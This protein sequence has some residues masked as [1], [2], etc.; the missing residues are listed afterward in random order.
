[1]REILFSPLN[2]WREQRPKDPEQLTQNHTAGEWHGTGTS[3][4]LWLPVKYSSSFVPC[5]IQGQGVTVPL[6]CKEAVTWR[7]RCGCSQLCMA[8]E[9][10]YTWWF[11]TVNHYHLQGRAV[12]IGVPAH[13]Y[14][15]GWRHAPRQGQAPVSRLVFLLLLYIFLCWKHIPRWGYFGMLVPFR[16]SLWSVRKHDVRWALPWYPE[17]YTWCLTAFDVRLSDVRCALAF[18]TSSRL[19]FPHPAESHHQPRLTWQPLPVPG[20]GRV[21][22]R[23]EEWLQPDHAFPR[24]GAGLVCPGPFS[25]GLCLSSCSGTCTWDCELA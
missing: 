1:M 18:S 20:P 5:V 4:V 15:Q 3:L 8:L 12:I 9:I 16:A 10:Q 6:N 2:S 19:P 25:F 17:T 22:Q 21:S 7:L 14:K 13:G 23:H 24:W 11:Q